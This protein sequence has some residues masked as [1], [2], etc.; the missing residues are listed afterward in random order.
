M[1]IFVMGL[2][3][4]LNPSSLDFMFDYSKTEA[5]G[6]GGHSSPFC[7]DQLETNQPTLDFPISQSEPIH[8]FEENFF[9][10]FNDNMRGT[11]SEY[12]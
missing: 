11:E 5:G 1:F 9:T 2:Y 6:H 7:L 12:S 4:F 3:S 8:L 10:M